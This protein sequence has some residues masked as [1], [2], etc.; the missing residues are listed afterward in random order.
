L[1]PAATCT[2]SIQY[3]TPAT[4]PGFPNI[5]SAAVANNGANG[6]STTL[7]LLAQ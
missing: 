1:A 2:V 5:G 3:A 7:G 4:R 6:G